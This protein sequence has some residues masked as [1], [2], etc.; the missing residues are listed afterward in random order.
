MK[1]SRKRFLPVCNV[2]QKQRRRL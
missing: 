1:R 2:F